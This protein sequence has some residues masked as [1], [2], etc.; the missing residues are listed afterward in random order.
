[1]WFLWVLYVMSGS[2]LVSGLSYGGWLKRWEI[3]GEI[4]L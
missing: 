3:K 4:F 1:M 2:W